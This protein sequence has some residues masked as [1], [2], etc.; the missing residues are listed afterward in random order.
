[1]AK[2]LQSFLTRL[3]GF[4]TKLTQIENSQSVKVIYYN[5]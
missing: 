4:K 1:M 5:K 3:T 2:V